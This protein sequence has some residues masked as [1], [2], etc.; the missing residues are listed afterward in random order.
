LTDRQTIIDLD[1]TRN[2][3]REAL[4]HL[5]KQEQK[6]SWIVMG[7]TFFKLE[8]DSVETI[9]NEDQER[10]D[11]EING[12]RDNLKKKMD[13]IKDLEGRPALKGFDLKPL[14]REEISAMTITT[15]RT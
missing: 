9:L 12:L 7:S 8:T 6:K 13:R 2:G 3:N 14:S 5:K 11:K 1:R 15:P 4:R 10:L